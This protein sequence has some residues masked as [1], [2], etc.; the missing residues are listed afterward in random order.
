MQSTIRIRPYAPEDAC[1]LR[2]L[3]FDTVR[4]VNRKDYSERQIEA[5]A[6][7]EITLDRWQVLLDKLVPF[8]A[9][10]DNKI[11]G[12][13]D[14]QSDGLIGHFYVDHNHQSM[15]IAGALMQQILQQGNK[16]KIPR[17]YSHVSITAKPFFE[18]YG[19]KVI[20]ERQVDLRGQTLINYR[21]ELRL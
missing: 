8:V 17:L 4:S 5:W 10:V 18:H 11:V 20:E 3:F 13:A 19:F 12:Y 2:A 15:G 21:M 16:S 7:D 1:T 14:L 9:E 6:S